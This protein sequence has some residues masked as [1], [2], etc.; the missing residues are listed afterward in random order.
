MTQ[1]PE[2]KT[3]EALA[4]SLCELAMT[5]FE[6]AGARLSLHG[7]API[8]R[9]AARDLPSRSALFDREAIA[10]EG[11]ILADASRDARYFLD[12]AVL[13][14][15]NLRFYAD[16]PL[17]VGGRV[18]GLLSL[19]DP[20]PRADFDARREALLT[21]L[22]ELS[23][24]IMTLA[25]DVGRQ[26]GLNAMLREAL[27]AQTER[28]ERAARAAA[29][30]YWTLDLTTRAL[31]W[32][33]GLYALYGLNPKTFT[34]TLSGHLD[35]YGEAAETVLSHLQRAASAGEDFDFAVT[36][37]RHN[38][39][40]QRRLHVQGGIERDAD[41]QPARLCA[42]VCDVSERVAAAP[43]A[44]RD[45][46]LMRL[47][48]ELRHPLRDILDIARHA[49]PD[50]AE[51]A[52]FSDALRADAETLARL[53]PETQTAPPVALGET[54]R[55]AAAPFIERAR[56][57]NTRL[58]LHFVDWTRQYARCDV[59][60]LEQVMHHLLS[61]ACKT[62]RGGVISV[63]V[64]QVQAETDAGALE[65]RLHVSVRD[66]GPGMDDADAQKLLSG[67]KGDLGLSIARTLVEMMDGHIGAYAHPGEGMQV[68]FEVPVRW[69]ETRAPRPRHL[70][71]D[72][73]RAAVAAAT[74]PAKHGSA[75]SGPAYA[76]RTPD[77]RPAPPVDEHRLNR[78]YLRALL[79]DMKLG[80]S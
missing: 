11:L 24:N 68:W 21:G 54:L 48:Q 36:I 10:G 49:G 79:Q 23:A 40:A 37:A 3:A 44:P 14:A 16:M 45:E 59:A 13:T 57:Q 28:L 9:G 42:V 62:T 71:P 8:G 22:A 50:G 63:T 20:A 77:P 15:P 80:L 6:V 53:A 41:G 78:D 38:D 27:K 60:R 46:A 72:P 61:H 12:P 35:I 69:V 26:S 58:N 33:D 76:P 67:A 39:K 29:F 43:E 70:A 56:V 34:P 18:M 73:M 52:A 31:Y 47:T 5:M 30:G 2:D 51:V 25:Q 74:E 65:T 7:A 66:S 17:T 55:A 19:I 4:G 64:S 1:S 32:S 75:R